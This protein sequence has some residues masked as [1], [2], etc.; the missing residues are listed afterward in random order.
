M[1]PVSN[2]NS[3]SYSPICRVWTISLCLP[4]IWRVPSVM[5]HLKLTTNFNSM[6]EAGNEEQYG[7]KSLRALG[8]YC[9]HCGFIFQSRTFLYTQTL[10]HCL[11][12]MCFKS[13]FSLQPGA[14][15]CIRVKKFNPNNSSTGLTEGLRSITLAEVK[16]CSE[17]PDDKASQYGIGVK[18]FAPAY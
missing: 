12:G 18:Y 3:T 14:T 6:K 11:D 1:C 2:A 5:K 8:P 10:N 17:V 13:S 4:S 9:P 15:L 7:E 16:W